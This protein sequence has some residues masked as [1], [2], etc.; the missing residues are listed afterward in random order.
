[1]MQVIV[2]AIDFGIYYLKKI[3]SK[4]SASGVYLCTKVFVA[5]VFTEYEVTRKC[6]ARVS[7]TI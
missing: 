5:L 7:L 6:S 4:M 1:M 3:Q 2:A